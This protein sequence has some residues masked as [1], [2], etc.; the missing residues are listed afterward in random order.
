M[1]N[2]P[3]YVYLAIGVAT[4]ISGI[5]KDGQPRTGNYSAGITTAAVAL[6]WFLLWR[7]GFFAPIGVAP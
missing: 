4:F 6:S 1:S 2:W 7:G 3:Q 5:V